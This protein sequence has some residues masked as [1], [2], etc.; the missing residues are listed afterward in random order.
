MAISI[1][2][3]LG[4]E[5]LMFPN[6]RIS[7]VVYRTMPQ[8]AYFSPITGEIHVNK[9]LAEE[10]VSSYGE[11]GA[12]RCVSFIM[13][14]E[15]WHSVATWQW[16]G[17]LPT[18]GHYTLL[19][20]LEDIRVNKGVSDMDENVWR[21]IQATY[22]LFASKEAAKE[23]SAAPPHP[24]YEYMDFVGNLGGLAYSNYFGEAMQLE[25][26][27]FP[28]YPLWEATLPL[29][30]ELRLLQ[31][32]IF[33]G[34]DCYEKSDQAVATAREI[35]EIIQPLFPKIE[36][37]QNKG[38][39]GQGDGNAQGDGQTQGG[40][41][42][43]QGE[44]IQIVPS[45][46]PGQGVGKPSQT[47]Q[48]DNQSAPKPGDS[49]VQSGSSSQDTPAQGTGKG[50][51][52]WGILPDAEIEG[53]L[54]GVT[55]QDATSPNS[56]ES[57]EV[58]N[59]DNFG[60]VAEPGQGRG[61]DYIDLNPEDYN[62]ANGAQ[63]KQ[64][65]IPIASQTAKAAI[66][67]LAPIVNYVTGLLAVGK[68]KGAGVDKSASQPSLSL[69]GSKLNVRKYIRSKLN[70]SE[71]DYY[72]QQ[73]PGVTMGSGGNKRHLKYL[74]MGGLSTCGVCCD[75]PKSRYITSI[76]YLAAQALGVKPTYMVSRDG[77]SKAI[78]RGSPSETPPTHLAKL[79]D[80]VGPD[81]SASE[82]LDGPLLL[83][84]AKR[85][86]ALKSKDP[87][88]GILLFDDECTYDPSCRALFAH[89][90]TLKVPTLRLSFN[91]G[92][93]MAQRRKDVLDR[94][95]IPTLLVDSGGSNHTATL[96]LTLK[97]VT[98]FLKDPQSFL[99]AHKRGM[100]YM[101]TE[102]TRGVP[103]DMPAG[104]P[105]KL[106]GVKSAG[107]EEVTALAAAHDMHCHCASCNAV[108]E[109]DVDI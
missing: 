59:S 8:N 80:A 103:T 25:A 31:P 92:S 45:G 93:G 55:E 76:I 16:P 98:D 54:G 39:P 51:R 107:M 21:G 99:A 52:I 38:E 47:V 100:V 18:R 22:K 53:L 32:D 40:G 70:P 15:L 9:A 102:P 71:K 85:A 26:E 105:G 75:V 97:Y 83:E 34:E 60:T 33:I 91:K 65:L 58:A 2:L 87:R 94:M 3:L 50:T 101:N 19:N 7:G 72:Y 17:D 79:L 57:S 81:P 28:S 5:A 86:G 10:L 61:R 104:Y 42:A 24:I 74:L 109:V 23:V 36:A 73:T 29:I 62:Q 69:D 108:P 82:A 30:A 77:E 63:V 4:R 1:P 48:G 68:I 43:V 44:S 13:R 27:K 84:L 12:G 88:V 106:A 66:K 78:L 95:S 37:N 90:G 11:V 41:Q 67:D 49:S 89:M 56:V 46:Q 64:L 35:F 14:H 96:H 20:L 6:R